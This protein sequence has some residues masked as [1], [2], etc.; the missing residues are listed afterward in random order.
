MATIRGKLAVLIL[1]ML[2][3]LAAVPSAFAQAYTVKV[4][5]NATLGNILTDNDGRTLY[6]FTPD[7]INTSSACYNQ[8]AVAWPPRFAMVD[9]RRGSARAA[10]RPVLDPGARNQVRTPQVREV[11]EG[12]QAHRLPN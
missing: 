5:K 2:L 12:S 11:A 6:R 3:M 9:A 4:A 7:V 8:C 1:A 10:P